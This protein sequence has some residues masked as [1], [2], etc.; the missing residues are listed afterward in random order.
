MFALPAGTAP[1][2]SGD[3]GL[4]TWDPRAR[5]AVSD[6]DQNKFM[7]RI[8]D[9]KPYSPDGEV[10]RAGPSPRPN[11]AFLVICFVQ[12][13]QKVPPGS[14]ISRIVYSVK[15]LVEAV[16]PRSRVSA[17]RSCWWKRWQPSPPRYGCSAGGLRFVYLGLVG[18]NQQV[19]DAEV[20]ARNFRQ[21]RLF[22]SLVATV[23]PE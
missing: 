11:A 20:P 3:Q 4:G 21:V 14:L 15:L 18:G 17:L 7:V 9:G 10:R 12:L 1:R 5:L 2:R 16:P 8:N 13:S 6:I 23:R 22:D 19:P